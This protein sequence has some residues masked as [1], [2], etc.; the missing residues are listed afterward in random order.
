MSRLEKIG[1]S[2]EWKERENEGGKVIKRDNSYMYRPWVSE[3]LSC[4]DPSSESGC[5]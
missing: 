5:H 3:C 1:P 2:P 4:C